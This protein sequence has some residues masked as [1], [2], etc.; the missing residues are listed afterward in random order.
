MCVRDAVSFELAKQFT[1]NV[2]LLPDMAHQLYPL[3]IRPKKDP[4]GLLLINR[5][6][7]EKSS[8]A[9]TSQFLPRTETDW[10]KLVGHRE[11]LI[12]LFRKV[13]NRSG[14][15]HMGRIANKI[16]MPVWISYSKYLCNE[17]AELFA[18]HQEIVSDR[19]HGHILAFVMSL[20]CT[21]LDNSYKKNSRYVAAWTAK[22]ELVK[23]LPP[24]SGKG[25]L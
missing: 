20:P 13:V 6:D 10:P 19:L 14:K 2:Y 15:L 21:V 12:D 17:A 5:L 3:S 7:T 18:E 16:L 25:N 22:S 11:I 8:E 24:T 4:E 23:Q 1:D 9:D